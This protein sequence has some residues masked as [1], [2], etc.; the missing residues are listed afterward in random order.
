MMWPLFA[1]LLGAGC[2]TMCGAVWGIARARGILLRV[3]VLEEMLHFLQCVES[4][5]DF[6]AQETPLLLY[7]AQKKARLHVLPLAFEGLQA[8]PE[9]PRQLAQRMALLSADGLMQGLPSAALDAFSTALCRLGTVAA[10][11]ECRE[12]RYAQAQL[13]RMCEESRKDAQS[14]QKLSIVL[15]AGAGACTALLLI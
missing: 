9:F 12:L 5:L 15:G 13:Q 6:R 10:G 8:G 1:K 7:S 4:E 14:R 3:Q 11:E 2:V